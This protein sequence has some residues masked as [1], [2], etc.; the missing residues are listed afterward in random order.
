MISHDNRRRQDPAAVEETIAR[1][2]EIRCQQKRGQLTG[3]KVAISGNFLTIA[4]RACDFP[5]NS[6]G[7]EQMDTTERTST[8]TASR[9]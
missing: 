1:W 8:S 2:P 5:R 7:D 6:D 9:S 3:L 4:V